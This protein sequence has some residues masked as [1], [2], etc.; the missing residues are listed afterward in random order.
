MLGKPNR[1]D[2]HTLTPYLMVVEVEPVVD[3]TK[4]AFGATEHF[5]TTGARGG[6]HVELKIG[7]SIIMIGGGNNTVSEPIV[8]AFFLYVD[9]VD[10]VYQSAINA[11]ANAM[12]PPEDGMFAEE[13]GAGVTDPFGNSWFFGKYGPQSKHFEG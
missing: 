6:L 4:A 2:F 10:A 12:L 1:P 5:R 3:F 7:D 11:G 8:S 13:R 9:D